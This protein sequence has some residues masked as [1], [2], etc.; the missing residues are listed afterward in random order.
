V[1]LAVSTLVLVAVSC[2]SSQPAAPPPSP[3]PPKS[4]V[5]TAPPRDPLAEP[6]PAGVTPNV[7]FPAVS[8]ARL[9]N[10]LALAV[11]AR[12]GFPVIDVRLVVRSGQ[13]S[14]GERSGVAALT[15]DL[16]KD[17]GAGRFS[18]RELVERAETLGGSL[19]I[20]T[21]RDATRIGIGVTTGDLEPA[22]ELVAAVAMK[23]RFSPDEFAKLKAREIDR[24][25]GRSRTSPG[26]LASMLLYRELYELP[27]SVHPY[28]RYDALPADLEAIK[29]DD[30]K[31]WAKAHVVP[32][33]A[34]LVVTGDVDVNA[35]T[36]AAQRWLGGWKGARPEPQS[37]SNPFASEALELYVVDRPASAQSLVLVGILGPERRSA[38]YAALMAANQVLGGGVAGRLFLDV[39][40]KRSLAYSTG[41]SVEEPAHGGMPLVLSAGTQTAKTTET[42]QA[43]LENLDRIG[44]S[45]PSAEEVER[46]TRFLSDSF[47]F[48]METAAALSELTA[49]LVVLGLPD[50]TYDEY[51]RAVRELTPEK[52]A[53]VAAGYYKKNGAVVVVAGDAATIAKPLTRVAAVKVVDPETFT[54]RQTLPKN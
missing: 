24:V 37:F 39:R 14:D 29:L 48:K 49:R 22:L 6:P 18:S 20:A 11:I 41:S 9:D 3:V 43:L 26:W 35:V 52:I 42:V 12:R 1:K 5:S 28:A 46:A 17:G 53:A 13:A 23:P 40:E 4:P 34:T 54:I 15:G 31:R 38:D 25:K 33:N 51:R 44:A 2:A 45:A 7:P 32:D 10:G 30:C 50:D 16:L 19:T 21:D 47:L 36:Q 27:T 8:H